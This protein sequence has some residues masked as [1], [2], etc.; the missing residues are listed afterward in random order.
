MKKI[1]FI[2]H[3]KTVENENRIILGHAH[4]ILSLAGQAQSREWAM[5]LHQEGIEKIYASDLERAKN[6]AQIIGKNLAVNTLETSPLIRERS[7]GIYN[8]KSEDLIEWIEYKKMP[9]ETRK[10]PNGQHDS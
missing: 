1:I 9:H 10:H 7:A 2:R 3:G 8:G 5:K 6:T 4:G